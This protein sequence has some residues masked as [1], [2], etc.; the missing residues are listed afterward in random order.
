MSNPA[1]AVVK[2]HY[3]KTNLGLFLRNLWGSGY[4]NYNAVSHFSNYR[5]NG[6]VYDDNTLVAGAWLP[7]LGVDAISKVETKVSAKKIHVGYK[8]KEDV[9][10]AVKA[11]LK[12]ARDSR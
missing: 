12:L 6:A 2:L 8:V 11:G 10:E 7:M 1:Q 9:P 5:L 4:N 3:Y